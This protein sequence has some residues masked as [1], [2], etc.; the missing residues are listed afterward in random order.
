MDAVPLE[1]V[2]NI[3][4]AAR[5]ELLDEMEDDEQE[6]DEDNDS[7]DDGAKGKTFANCEILQQRLAIS[8]D[9]DK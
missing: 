2:E 3:N 7:D 6:A 9:I 8:L 5:L 4:N 1:T